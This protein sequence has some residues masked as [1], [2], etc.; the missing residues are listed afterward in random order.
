MQNVADYYKGGFSADAY[1]ECAAMAR[2]HVAPPAPFGWDERMVRFFFQPP[3]RRPSAP[4]DTSA[5]DRILPFPVTINAFYLVNPNEDDDGYPFWI[6]QIAT[7]GTLTPITSTRLTVHPPQQRRL[8]GSGP[9]AFG[10][11]TQ[12]RLSEFNKGKARL[13]NS[14]RRR[15]PSLTTIVTPTR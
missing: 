10:G 11:Y 9:A 15:W 5:V 2:L 4:E 13:R 8:K 1:A 3:V 14:E 12:S 6:A 7:K